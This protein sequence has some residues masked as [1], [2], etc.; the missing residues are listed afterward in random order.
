MALESRAKVQRL[1]RLEIVA[2]DAG[3]LVDSDHLG[4]LRHGGLQV[5]GDAGP[6]LVLQGAPDDRPGVEPA[7]VIRPA[8]QHV[9]QGAGVVVDAPAVGLDGFAVGRSHAVRPPQMC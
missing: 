2:G 4:V 5:E 6:G 7:V 8:Q 1:V 9:A 3:R